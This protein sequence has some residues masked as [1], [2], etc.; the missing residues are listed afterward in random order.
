M[1]LRSV[2]SCTT[3]QSSHLCQ[4]SK[5]FTH[6]IRLTSWCWISS[7]LQSPTSYD[8]DMNFSCTVLLLPVIILFYIPS[9][10]FC[11]FTGYARDEIINRNCR[12]LQV[13]NTALCH[14]ISILYCIICT[15]I[16]LFGY[17]ATF[18]N[19][20]LAITYCN[21]LLLHNRGKTLIQK[22]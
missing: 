1:L 16:E 17:L 4:V 21:I 13:R 18:H 22:R 11:S 8:I 20:T 5:C 14:S 15:F 9:N 3:R 12:F 10:A 2:R 19:R 6:T 7:P